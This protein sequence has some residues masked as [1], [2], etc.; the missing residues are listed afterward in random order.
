MN[1]LPIIIIAVL[2][3]VLFGAVLGW[4]LARKNRATK[5]QERF[6]SDEYDHTV[7]ALGNENKA[8]TELGG[9][10]KTVEGYHLQSLS[11]VDR[12]RYMAD[13]VAVQSNFVDEPS[14]AILAADRLII[15]VM[16]KR[17]YPLSDFNQRAADISVNYPD[18]VSN[19]RNAREIASKNEQHTANTEELRQAM[20][21]YRALFD[22]LL[23]TTPVV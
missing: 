16:Q 9:R 11:E 13:W 22:E 5:L 10:R 17:N 4:L 14:E 6:G 12:D 21:H 3:L 23:E 18:L 1:S 2:V 15:E 20:I 7:Q 19:Y 8:Q